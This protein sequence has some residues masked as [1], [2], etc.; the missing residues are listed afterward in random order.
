MRF[1]KIILCLTFFFLSD[2]SYT[3]VKPDSDLFKQ[4]SKADSLLFEA[5]FNNCDLEALSMVTA[6]SLKFYHDTSGITSGKK[7]FIASIK[8]NICSI[9]YKP[10]RKLTPGTQLIYPLRQNGKIYGAIQKGIHDFYAINEKKEAY[11]T[12]SAKF[13]NLWIKKNDRW[14]LKNVLSYDHQ[15]PKDSKSNLDQNQDSIE[16]LLRKNNVPALGLAK[17]RN[18]KVW[19]VSIY[20]N[21]YGEKQA[22]IDAVFN[23]ASL[24]KPIVTMLT[25]SLVENGD[26]ELDEPVYSYWTDPDVKNSAYSKLLT[27]RHILTHQTGFPNWRWEAE[28]K[29]LNFKYKPGDGYGYSGEGYE[30]LKKAIEAKFKVPIEKLADSLLFKPLGMNNTFFTWN[31]NIDESK[32]AKWHNEEGKPYEQDYRNNNVS[33][34]DDLLTTIHDYAK[35]AEYVFSKILS[36]TPLYNNMVTRGN[37][38]ENNTV[39]G[40]GWEILP[41]LKDDE[42][43]LLHTGGDIGVNT[44]IM[45]LPKTLEGIVIFTNGDNGNKLYYDLIEKNLSLGKQINNTAQ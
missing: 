38:I 17:I 32:F 41:E 43:A 11:L 13:T 1:F 20:G 29:K 37:G 42:F 5:G 15:A 26:W 28:D 3:Q 21:L 2:Y 45:L 12:S 8:N 24:T 18:G 23:V 39:I 27:T 36:N 40:L 6:D 31:S 35:F 16:E 9:E 44:L 4:I 34:A 7:E 33:A 30:Y 14:M 19:Q 10:F 25:L 22:P